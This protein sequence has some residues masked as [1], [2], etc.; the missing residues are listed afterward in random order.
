MR[1]LADLIFGNSIVLHQLRIIGVG[2]VAEMET[3]DEWA[4]SSVQAMNSWVV[5]NFVYIGTRVN[6][7][8]KAVL[9]TC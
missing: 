5:I 7:I 6:P 9:A 3:A 8:C 2:G 1:A 4:S